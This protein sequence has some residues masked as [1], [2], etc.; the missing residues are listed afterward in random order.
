MASRYDSRTT[1]FSPAG[2]LFQVEYAMEAISHTGS[3]IG[4][5]SKDGIVL[6]AEKKVV[7]KLLD[8]TKPEKLLPIDSHIGAA[9][10]GMTADANVLVHAARVASQ[11]Y[12]F[13]Y[14]EPVPI[15]YLVRR[16]CDIKQSYTQFGGLRPYGVAFLYAGWDKR[17]G[18]Q[19]YQ[20]D[21]SG[22]Y[23]GWHATAIGA[24]SSGAL[25]MLRSDYK[26]GCTLDEARTLAMNVL[27]KTVEAVAL[28]SDKIE[29]AIL[30]KPD[31]QSDVEF[32]TLSRLEVDE[33][34]K[35]ILEEREA[36]LRSL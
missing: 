35:P 21:P 22:N 15:E 18:Y 24:N 27:A 25:S 29:V 2:R 11:R 13:S 17:Y 16:V 3:C 8:T 30:S 31:P 12:L 33:L 28:S 32:K 23:T 7:G 36:R 1:I 19:L 5:L 20:S 9:V 4:V 34:I 10:A 6:V 14:Q 26:E